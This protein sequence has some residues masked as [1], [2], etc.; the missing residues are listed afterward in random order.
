[1]ATANSEAQDVLIQELIKAVA[2]QDIEAVD[3]VLRSGADVAAHD[4]AVL[5][6]AANSGSLVPDRTKIDPA[7]QAV[8]NRLLDEIIERPRSAQSVLAWADTITNDT[9]AVTLRRLSP[10]ELTCH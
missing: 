6:V 7:R 1:M 9:I 5:S 4:Y 8:L 3:R 2:E 10:T